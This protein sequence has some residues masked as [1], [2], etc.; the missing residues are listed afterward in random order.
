MR[1]NLD[2]GG[3]EVTLHQRPEQD[4]QGTGPVGHLEPDLGSLDEGVGGSV[5]TGGQVGPVHRALRALE[6]QG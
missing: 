6:G 3:V 2:P 1:P 4:G 5:E